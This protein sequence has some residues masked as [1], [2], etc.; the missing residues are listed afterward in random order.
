MAT[1]EPKVLKIRPILG[2]EKVPDPEF[3]K[4]LYAT[5]NGVKGNPLFPT[6]PSI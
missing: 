5:H 4:Q 3:L 1:K 2:V 6:R